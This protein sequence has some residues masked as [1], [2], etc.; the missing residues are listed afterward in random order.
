MKNLL[1]IGLFFHQFAFSQTNFKTDEFVQSF[2]SVVNK[3]LNLFSKSD[4]EIIN[5]TPV[6][7]NLSFDEQLVKLGE[8][9]VSADFLSDNPEKDALLEQLNEICQPLWNQS[10]ATDEE[11]TA[12]LEEIGQKFAKLKNGKVVQFLFM[13]VIFSNAIGLM[14]LGAPLEE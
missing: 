12:V 6:P 1:F 3:N 2:G 10:F 4:I 7:E 14:F 5:Q 9:K 8:A 11:A 13:E